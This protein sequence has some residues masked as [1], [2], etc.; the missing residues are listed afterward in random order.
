MTTTL[1]GSLV[2]GP[3]AP[4]ATAVPGATAAPG[5]PV[6]S[7]PASARWTPVCRYDELEPERGVA[8]LVCGEQVAIFRLHDGSLHA[9]DHLDPVS[10]ANVM[11]RGIVGTRG[12]T[13]TVASPMY[14]QVYDLR[15]GA[16]LDD[17]A[18][19]LRVFAVREVGGIVEVGG[20]VELGHAG[21]GI[22]GGIA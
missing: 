14:K 16:C 11:A 21:T 3:A 17:P 9:L 1:N 10:G 15:T 5:A 12:Q 18:V 22:G 7:S 2:A 6:T 13:P 4:G 19:R 20:A 8:A